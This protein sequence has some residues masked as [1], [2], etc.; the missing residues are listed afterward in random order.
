MLWDIIRKNL[1]SLITTIAKYSLIPQYKDEKNLTCIKN[2]KKLTTCT[3][4]YIHPITPFLKQLQTITKSD[5]SAK[6]ESL[7]Q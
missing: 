1:Y 2:E 3:T 4:A 6:I 5:R 7:L